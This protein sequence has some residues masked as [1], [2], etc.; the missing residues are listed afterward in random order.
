M[1]TVVLDYPAV[2]EYLETSSMQLSLDSAIL[3]R[4][5]I[6]D[7]AFLQVGDTQTSL[8]HCDS[9]DHHD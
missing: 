5:R 3:D 7:N 1:T 4:C 6:A 8:L 2:L 9:I